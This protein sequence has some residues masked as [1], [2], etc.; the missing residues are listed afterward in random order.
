MFGMRGGTLV[1]CRRR[2]P[3]YREY[4]QQKAVSFKRM[5]SFSTIHAVETLAVIGINIGAFAFIVG[6]WRRP[7]RNSAANV[8]VFAFGLF[9][10]ALLVRLGFRAVRMESATSL[11]TGRVSDIDAAAV[12]ALVAIQAAWAFMIVR[13]SK[14][15]DKIRKLIVSMIT[16]TLAALSTVLVCFQYLGMLNIQGKLSL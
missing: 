1:L 5:I 9:T 2:N 4:A 6:S 14:G 12:V 15:F 8:V 16:A 10:V 13:L 11:T 7:L 3:T